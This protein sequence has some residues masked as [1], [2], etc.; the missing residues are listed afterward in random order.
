MANVDTSSNAAPPVIGGPAPLFKAPTPTNPGFVFGS[1]GGRYLVLA[2]PGPGGSEG[3]TVRR[4]MQARRRLFDDQ[5]CCFFGVLR[6]PQAIAAAVDETPG[7]R[8]FLDADGELSRLYGYL[9]EDGAARSGWMVLDPSFRVLAAAPLEDGASL[10]DR[11]AA[12]PRPDD[13]AGVPLHAPVLIVPRVFEP[14]FCARLIQ[15]Y[16]TQGGSP[17]G[18]MR[19]VEGRTVE[20]RDTSHKRRSDLL[21]ADAQLKAAGRARL[22]QRLLPEIAKAFQFTVTRIERDIVAC[23]DAADA[24]FFRAHRDNTTK[25]TAHRKFAVTL[26]LNT[27]AYDGGSCASPSSEPAPIAPRWAAP[28]CSPV[29]CCTRPPR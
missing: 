12:L 8:W 14:D 7:V 3:E 18:F 5:F 19:E 22:S 6:D 29:R 2:F 16:D 27:G 28:W 26:N 1:V 9:G 11:L 15:E 17:S 4:T 25:G 23:Y 10:L 24:G 20:V 13:H 21:I